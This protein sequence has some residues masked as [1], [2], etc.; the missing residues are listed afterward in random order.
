MV[1]LI[2]LVVVVD[3]GMGFTFHYDI[4]AQIK[5]LNQLEKTT[6]DSDSITSDRID[7]MRS[8]VLARIKN[9]QDTVS[10]SNLFWWKLTSGLV[11]P[12]ILLTL[13]IMILS[14]KGRKSTIAWMGII[15]TI[16]ATMSSLVIIPDLPTGGSVVFAASL[17]VLM[18]LFWV[19]G[20]LVGFN[21]TPGLPNLVSKHQEE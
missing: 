9:R 11:L 17:P 16:T 15:I 2:T 4:R 6:A 7:L 21:L 13:F 3:H 5:E 19:T 1:S 18:Q 12:S 14:S 8:R 20:L 10:S